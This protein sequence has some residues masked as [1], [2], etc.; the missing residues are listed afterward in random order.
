MTIKALN[1]GRLAWIGVTAL[2]F[3]F[4]TGCANDPYSQRRI[5]R[6][7]DHLREEAAAIEKHEADGSRRVQYRLDELNRKNTTD[8]ARFNERVKRVGDYV[9]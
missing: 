4:S 1:G 7:T 2:A 5:Q 6:R 8:A 9:W 3:S